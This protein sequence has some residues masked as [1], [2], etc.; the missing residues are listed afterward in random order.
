MMANL[1]FFPLGRCLHR[2]LTL[3]ET[4]DFIEAHLL[5]GNTK[6][7]LKRFFSNFLCSS[8]GLL[9][10]GEIYQMKDWLLSWAVYFESLLLEKYCGKFP[11]VLLPVSWV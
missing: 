4:V 9:S 10:Q 5:R 7:Y 11:K 1:Y 8:G 6:K 2:V 3:F